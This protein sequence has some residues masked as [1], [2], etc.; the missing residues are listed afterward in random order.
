VEMPGVEPGSE[1]DHPK[2]TTCVFDLRFLTDW[3]TDR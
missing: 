3:V 2:L 1:V